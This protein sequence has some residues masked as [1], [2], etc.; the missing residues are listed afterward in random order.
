MRYLQGTRHILG[1][2][3]KKPTD[4]KF[5]DCTSEILKNVAVEEHS[6]SESDAV[7]DS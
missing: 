6:D 7:E 2:I 3:T 1:K 4:G 5:D